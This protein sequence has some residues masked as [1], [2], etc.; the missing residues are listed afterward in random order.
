MAKVTF[1]EPDGSTHSNEDH[2]IE[3]DTDGQQATATFRSHSAWP[4]SVKGMQPSVLKQWE[5]VV[6]DENLT[7]SGPI[8]RVSA[9]TV[10]FVLD[11]TGP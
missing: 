10:V 3:M 11:L 4:D 5:I 2:R 9:R 6:T 1:I 7:V 8:S